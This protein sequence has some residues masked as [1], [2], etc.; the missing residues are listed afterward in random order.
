MNWKPFD[1]DKPETIPGNNR[2]YFQYLG[3]EISISTRAEFS[4][5][6]IFEGDDMRK[7][8]QVVLV[9]DDTVLK[10]VQD[11]I[12]FINREFNCMPREAG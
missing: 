5:I 8:G 6:A 4:S 11:A 10:N 9:A 7:D 1:L 12:V 3:Y 2:C